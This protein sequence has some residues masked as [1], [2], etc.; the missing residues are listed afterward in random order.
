MR[1]YQRRK[2]FGVMTVDEAKG[3]FMALGYNHHV[4][5]ALAERKVDPNDL[6]YMDERD[7]MEHFLEW[8][9]II[10]YTGRIMDAVDNIR[11]VGAR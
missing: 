2:E 9:G 5:E 4:A 10:G 11:N 7:V 3:A 1:G 8:N 6:R